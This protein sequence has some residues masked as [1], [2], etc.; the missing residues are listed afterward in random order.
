MTTQTQID[1]Y[2]NSLPEPRRTEMRALHERILYMHPDSPLWFLDGKNADNKTVSNPNIGYGL[3]QLRYADGSSR[4]F[5]RVGISATSSGI[6]V[7]IL[8]LADKHYLSETY[9]SRLGKATVTGYCIKFRSLAVINR[10]VLEEA[11]TDA[12]TRRDDA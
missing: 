1:D 6:S 9:S 4:A 12:L 2:L 7:Y 3:Q 5:Y 11:I 10:E 8:G